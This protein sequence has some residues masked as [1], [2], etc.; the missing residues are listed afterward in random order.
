MVFRSQSGGT[1][2]NAIPD[3]NR[4]GTNSGGAVSFHFSDGV[5][6]GLAG[7][8]ACLVGSVEG[9][10]AEDDRRSHPG[11]KAHRITNVSKALIGVVKL[12]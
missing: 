11:V 10:E 1:R 12:R 2:T 4:W 8:L 6:A 7:A 3:V 5:I 9:C